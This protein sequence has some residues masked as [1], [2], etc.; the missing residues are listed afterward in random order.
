M[1]KKQNEMKKEIADIRK[2]M[3]SK[4]TTLKKINR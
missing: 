4:A 3:D 2:Q 1:I